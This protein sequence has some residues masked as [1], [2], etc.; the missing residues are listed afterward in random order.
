MGQGIALIAIALL[1][2]GIVVCSI[3]LFF[4]CASP[5]RQDEAED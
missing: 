3:I 5:R 4:W 2:Y 1:A